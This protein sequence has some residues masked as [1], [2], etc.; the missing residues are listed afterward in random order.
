MNVIVESVNMAVSLDDARTGARQDGTA[1]DAEIETWVRAFTKEAEHATGRAVVEQTAR[2]T[3]DRFSDAIKLP[4]LPVRSVMVR[5]LDTDKVMH[6][7]DPADYIVDHVSGWIVPAPDKAWPATATR[8]NAVE[9]DV[10]C[11]YGPDHTTTPAGFKSY[12]LGKLQ[13]HYAGVAA[14]HLERLL[15]PYKV[16]V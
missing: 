11:G 4:A 9:V 1:L 15:W 16:F 13:A 2:V 6:T 10:V 7:L 5:Y 8:I 14:P 12:I 3:L